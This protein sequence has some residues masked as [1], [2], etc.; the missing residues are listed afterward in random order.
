MV[1]GLVKIFIIFGVENGCFAHL[2]IEKRYLILGKGPID[3]LDKTTIT[4]EAEYYINF[5]D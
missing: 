1:K 5:S 2:S 4:T 3:G